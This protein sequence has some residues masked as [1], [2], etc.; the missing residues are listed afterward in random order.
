[1]K[2][3]TFLTITQRLWW[4]MKR[5]HFTLIMLLLLPG[6][7]IFVFFFAFSSVRTAGATTY[8]I[9]VINNDNGLAEEIKGVL[10]YNANTTG[11][12][13]ETVHRKNPEI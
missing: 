6:F 10:N 13:E 11:I 7:I 2:L 1:M 12:T 9:V 5:N 4:E 3:P 8:N